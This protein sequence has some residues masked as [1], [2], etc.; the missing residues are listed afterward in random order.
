MKISTYPPSWLLRRWNLFFPAN[1][2]F[3]VKDYS[4]NIS[5]KLLSSEIAIKAYFHFLHCKSMETFLS[6]HSN[7]STWATA[8]KNILI[9][10]VNVMNISA[11]FQ[12]HTP[13]GFCWDDFFFTNLVFQ[14]PC[15]PIKFSSLDK[16]HLLGRG[17]LK[18]H[19]CKTFVNMSAVR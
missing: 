7:E 16:I 11:K 13:Y 6:C 1:L 2:A 8:I 4:R 5:V 14:L 18:E 3:L 12:L 15:Q 17:L 9:V 19:F 10:E